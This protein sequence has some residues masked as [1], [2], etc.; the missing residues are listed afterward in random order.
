MDG[1]IPL[2]KPRGMTSFDCVA[3]MRGILHQKKIGHSGTLDP[4]V[5]GVL[6]ICVGKATKVV[7]YLMTS[8]KVYMGSITFGFST[9]TEDLDGEVV[10]K[11]F[12]KEPLTDDQIDQAMAEL[13]GEIIQIPPIYSAIKVNGK[14]L[15]EYARQGIDVKRP[16][17]KITVQ[18]FKRQG[19]SIF[20][21]TDGTQTVNFEVQCSKGTYVRTLAVDVG[22][23]L[24]I[25]AVMSKLTRVK[26]GGFKLSETVT[27]AQLELAV[28]HENVATLMYP[29]DYALKMYPHFS[30][31]E[32]LNR[33]VQNGAILQRSN[34]KQPKNAAP[35]LVL[36]FE[37]QV[38]ALY[39]Y[40]E[41]RVAYRPLTMLLVN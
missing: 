4:N 28:K 38:Q 13:T 25:P 15:Y 18:T 19:K 17:R 8:G 1:I 6:P 12:L 20:N 7:N 37:N 5:D 34:F 23:Y 39:Q 9:T 30:L 10:K 2:Y 27:F 31:N 14:K 29:L 35:V 32:D 11:K 3:K 33:R 24:G 22:K 36:T 41:Q 26:S 21:S 16:E 40:D